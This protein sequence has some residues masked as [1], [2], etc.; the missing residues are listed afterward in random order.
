MPRAGR[1]RS[2]RRSVESG[3]GPVVRSLVAET[4]FEG[5]ASAVL[6]G[7]GDVTGADAAGVRTVTAPHSAVTGTGPTMVT[8]DGTITAHLSAP[9]P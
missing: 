2:V 6:T 3:P 7:L 4:A 8:D 1:P 5:C 9:E